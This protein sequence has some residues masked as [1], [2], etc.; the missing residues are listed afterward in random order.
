MESP[1]M[2]HDL[3]PRVEAMQ[4]SATLA[5]S[6]RA[7]AL[8]REG[9]PVIALSAGEPDFDTPEPIREAGQRAIQEGHTHYTANPGTPELRA[10]I[11]RKLEADNGLAYEPGDIVCS[12]GA[13][14]SV[15][16][17]VVVLC[18][19]GDEVVIPAPYWVSYPEMTRLAGA[20]PVTVETSA[21]QGYKMQPEALEAALSG[22][23]R[24]LMLNSPSNPTGAV[25][26]AA[27][28]DAFAEVLRGYEDVIVI[29]DEI[30]EHVIYD[31][32]H[33][34]FASRPGMKE[35]TVTINGFSKAYAMTGWR[36]G[37]L[38]APRW[39][40]EATAKVQS[41]FTSAPSAVTQQAGIAALEMDPE[42]VRQMV[43]AFRE[44]RAFVL[45]ALDRMPGVACPRPEGAFYLFPDISHYLGTTAPSGRSIETSTDLCFYLL[46]EHDVALVPGDAF[47]APSGVRLSYAASA[48]DLRAAMQ[49]I[50]TGLAALR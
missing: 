15:A 43:R 35:R 50:E 23:S 9:R 48:G 25:Y 31:A 33:V 30:Y 12:N 47:G 36:L 45:A 2:D 21:A 40:A 32:E 39:I 28:L 5:M 19:P 44:R 37:Y 6:A 10:A 46:E 26:S 8:K 4:P 42:P 16:Q 20:E 24:L 17:A 13:K 29:A 7:K 18:R 3:N 1:T 41:Q 27:E 38:A 22:R 11:A 14:Q 49:R 34:S